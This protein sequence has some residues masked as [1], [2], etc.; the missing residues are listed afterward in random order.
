MTYNTQISKLIKE[1]NDRGLVKTASDLEEVQAAFTGI[2]YVIP[3]RRNE[4]RFQK[5]IVFKEPSETGSGT[6]FAKKGEPVIQIDSNGN[7]KIILWGM[8]TPLSQ[9]ELMQ[10][11]EVGKMTVE[12][13]HDQYSRGDQQVKKFLAPVIEHAEKKGPVPY[14]PSDRRRNYVRGKLAYIAGELQ[15]H[16]Y[17]ILYEKIRTA[18]DRYESSL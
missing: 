5:D 4:P 17:T 10:E 15:K 9:K 6:P 2:P 12:K 1:F 14:S 11:I 13:L 16:G 8:G 7:E 18:M 3:T